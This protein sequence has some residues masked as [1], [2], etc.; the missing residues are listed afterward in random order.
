MIT[1][2]L[3][4]QEVGVNWSDFSGLQTSNHPPLH[5]RIELFMEHFLCLQIRW[6]TTSHNWNVS[7]CVIFQIP[8]TSLCTGTAADPGFPGGRQPERGPP[9]Y[10]LTKI[11]LYWSATAEGYCLVNW[12]LFAGYRRSGHVNVVVFVRLLSYVLLFEDGYEV[13]FGD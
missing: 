10:Y 12:W 2:Y 5:P 3:T 9:T 7:W 4:G 6:P 1:R 11:C 8:E 13:T